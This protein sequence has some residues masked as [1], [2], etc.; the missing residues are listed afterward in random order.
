M[1]CNRRRWRE[2]IRERVNGRILVEGINMQGNTDLI[3]TKANEGYRRT[4]NDY[5]KVTRKTRGKKRNTIDELKHYLKLVHIF[6]RGKLF[7]KH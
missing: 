4:K 3:Y 5:I 2:G 6:L 7:I 1:G